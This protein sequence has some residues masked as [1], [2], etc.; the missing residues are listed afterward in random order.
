MNTAIKEGKT[1][2]LEDTISDEDYGTSD[3]DVEVSKSS[4]VKKLDEV[5]SKY[6]HS[7]FS[8]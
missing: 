2:F 5:N 4:R 1:N 6:T 7:R 8:S 3:D